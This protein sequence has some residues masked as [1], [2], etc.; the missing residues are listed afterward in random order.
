[1]GIYA[2]AGIVAVI[3]SFV[4]GF[5]PFETA[6]MVYALIGASFG[7]LFAGA[8]RW[9]REGLAAIIGGM[10][11]GIFVGEVLPLFIE[12]A[13]ENVDSPGAFLFRSFPFLFRAAILWIAIS[14]L[15]QKLRQHGAFG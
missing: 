4:L 8:N 11:I 15:I 12:Q 1:M 14:S 13:L 10:V 2:V 3:T 9:A 5:V 7:A 6:I